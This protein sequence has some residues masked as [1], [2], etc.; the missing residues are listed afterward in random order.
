M[1][2]D[3]EVESFCCDSENNPNTHTHKQKDSRRR[4][5]THTVK[6]GA[7][8]DDGARTFI[9]TTTPRQS[10]ADELTTRKLLTML[11]ADRRAPQRALELQGGI[12]LGADVPG[13]ASP[14]LSRDRVGRHPA[15]ALSDLRVAAQL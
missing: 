15:R 2:L 3:F 4:G 1:I 7:G 6:E 10:S 13:A 9:H 11:A 14:P 12:P 5:V 8:N